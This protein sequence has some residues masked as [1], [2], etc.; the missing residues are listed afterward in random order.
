MVDI[1][2]PEVH[3][4]TSPR[5]LDDWLRHTPQLPRCAA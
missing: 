3:R 5:Q 4:F 1:F 2:G